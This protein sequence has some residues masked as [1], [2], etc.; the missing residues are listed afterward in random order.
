MYVIQ[1]RTFH[2]KQFEQN[3]TN[4][5]YCVQNPEQFYNFDRNYILYKRI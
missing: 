3:I 4:H 1:T 2:K 5:K